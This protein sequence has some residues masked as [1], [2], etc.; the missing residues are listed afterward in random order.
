MRIQFDLLSKGWENIKSEDEE[1]HFNTFEEWAE[2]IRT[3]YKP[4]TLEFERSW[5]MNT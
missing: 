5:T 3:K 1:I 2:N 4:S